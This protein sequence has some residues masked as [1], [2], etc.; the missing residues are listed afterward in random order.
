MDDST[1]FH[2]NVGPS[3]TIRIR[4]NVY[5]VHSR[6]IGERIEVRLF[7]DSLEVWYAQK[8]VETLPRLYG[9]G[10]HR[11]QYRHI[12]EWL[13]RKPRAFE[14]YRYLSDLFPTSRFRMAYD[15][16]TSQ[17]PT[18]AHK[19]Y[20]GILYVA[21][22]KSEC[23]VDEALRQLLEQGASISVEAVEARLG[24]EQ[25]AAQAPK[26]VVDEID[27]GLYDTLLETG[28]AGYE[29]LAPG[30]VPIHDSTAQKEGLV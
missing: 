14:Q 11:I 10:K 7:A 3:S 13:R 18:R 29:P 15:A 1:I 2:V 26:V 20:L 17:S 22:Q 5:S 12:I 21:A 24:S 27:L 25:Q 8:R 19:E 30:E 9:S 23:G 16:L 28:E 4:K 6:L